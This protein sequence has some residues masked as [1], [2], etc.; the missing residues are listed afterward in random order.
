MSRAFVD[1]IGTLIDQLL[2]KPAKCVVVPLDRPPTK[3][4]FLAVRQFILDLV[5]EWKTLDIRDHVE[6]LAMIMG[7]GGGKDASWRKPLK[8]FCNLSNEIAAANI[9]PSFGIY[10]YN[11][12]AAPTALYVPQLCEIT[13][14]V[15][16]EEL[17][18]LQRSLHLPHHAF[19]RDS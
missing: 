1:D 5:P 17:L 11:Q 2:L 14:Q 8:K 10:L 12:K 7:P 16:H 15:E 19:P 3:D 13:K 9:A 6:Y 4:L 18:A